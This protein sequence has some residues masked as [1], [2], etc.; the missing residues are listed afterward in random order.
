VDYNIS[1]FDISS[2]VEILK[3]L[4]IFQIGDGADKFKGGK[5]ILEPADTSLK[6]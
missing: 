2:L 5:L 3:N 6:W 4:V 1:L